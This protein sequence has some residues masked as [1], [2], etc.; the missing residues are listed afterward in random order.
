MDSVQT[1]GHATSFVGWL[2]GQRPVLEE[3]HQDVQTLVLEKADE[4]WDHDVCICIY[5]PTSASVERVGV[6]LTHPISDHSEA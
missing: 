5:P 6:T 4:L 3:E 1:H 2:N